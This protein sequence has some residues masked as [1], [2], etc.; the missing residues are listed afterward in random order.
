MNTYKR[1]RFSPDFVSYAVWLYY[2][3]NLSHREIEDLL[4]ARGINVSRAAISHRS[5]CCAESIQSGQAL[6]RGA[7]L[8]STI[9]SL[10]RTRCDPVALAEYFLSVAQQRDATSVHGE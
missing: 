8:A 7:A 6:G 2:R 9:L 5:C 10:S 4:A 1:H 3:F